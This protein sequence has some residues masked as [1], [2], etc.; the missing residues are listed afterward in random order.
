MFFHRLAEGVARHTLLDSLHALKH[1]CLAFTSALA[2]VVTSARHVRI[3]NIDTNDLIIVL[4]QSS[5]VRLQQT[6]ENYI[7]LDQARLVR[8]A[9]RDE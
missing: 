5:V 2:N 7:A 8:L 9:I 6:R 3:K 1:A 4:S